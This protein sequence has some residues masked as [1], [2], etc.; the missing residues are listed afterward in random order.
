M[1]AQHNDIRLPYDP[2]I[3]E[4]MQQ[5]DEARLLTPEQRAAKA[6]MLRALDQIDE[7]LGLKSTIAPKTTTP[8]TTKPI[9]PDAFM[10][11][12]QRFDGIARQPFLALQYLWTMPNRAATKDDLTEPVFGDSEEFVDK[13]QIHNIRRDLNKFFRCHNLPFKATFINDYLAV[14]QVDPLPAAK[15]SKPRQSRR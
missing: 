9:P 10:F 13:G 6:D 4:R 1:T 3:L 2:K 5:Q 14:K 8:N 12:G 15:K 7:R 11:N